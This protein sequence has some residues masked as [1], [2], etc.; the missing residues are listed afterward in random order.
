[1][2]IIKQTTLLF[3]LL[4]CNNYSSN[5][6]SVDLHSADRQQLLNLLSEVEEAI[7]NKDIEQIKKH[8]HPKAFITFQDAKVAHGVE[9]IQVYFEDKLGGSSAILKSFK[10]KASVDAPAEFYGDTASAFGHTIDHFEFAT[11]NSFELKSQWSAALFKQNGQWL[12]TS[13]HFS[14]N[15]FNNP[16]LNTAKDK[17]MLF[18]FIAFVAGLFLMFFLARY[19]FKK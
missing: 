7:N 1:M 11:G 14:A 17:L 18:S 2:K 5:A 16:L 13:L 12:L 15:M 10:T 8:I 6:Q 19:W 4:L 3:F 9:N